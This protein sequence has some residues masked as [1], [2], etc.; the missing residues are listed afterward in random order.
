VLIP[1]SKLARISTPSPTPKRRIHSP[2]VPE[3]IPG[4]FLEEVPLPPTPPSKV[5]QPDQGVDRHQE[6]Q[7]EILE[8]IEDLA[9]NLETDDELEQQLL[10]KL[11]IQPQLSQEIFGDVDAS[12]IILGG[13]SSRSHKPKNDR[14]YITYITIYIEEPPAFL[15]VFVYSLYTEKPEKRRH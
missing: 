6:Y 10:N 9:I 14:D 15:A 5:M 8:T 13:R 3:P 4:A 12:N 2:Q 11:E 7:Q 1:V